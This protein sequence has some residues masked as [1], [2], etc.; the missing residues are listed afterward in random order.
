MKISSGQVLLGVGI[1]VAVAAVIAG[2]MVAGSPAEGRMRRLDAV[3]A[4][5]LRSIAASID[6][7]WGRHERLPDS[8]G[9]LLVDPRARVSTEDPETEEDYEYRVMEDDSY[10]LCAVFA[11]ASLSDNRSQDAFWLHDAGRQCFSLSPP[12]AR[13]P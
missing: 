3:R 1:T 6:M 9:E 7:F 2:V 8:L 12:R 10:E 5:D 4:G 13:S 11:L